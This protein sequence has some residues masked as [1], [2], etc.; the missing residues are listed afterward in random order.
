MGGHEFQFKQF[1]I[2]QDR[3]GMKVGTDSV[4][5][6]AWVEIA[7]AQKILD[8]GTGTG[9]IALM[10]AQRSEAQI[11]AVEIDSEAC[12]QARENVAKS[13]WHSRIQIHCGS[14][15]A[16]AETCQTRYELLVTNPPFFENVFK[17][18]HPARRVA[19]HNDQLQPDELLQVAKKLL[20]AHGRLAVIYP[21]STAQYVQEKSQE[22]GLSCIRKLLM[23][24]LP[25]NPIKRILMEF[26]FLETPPHKNFQ[27]TS[28]TI[29][30]SQ[31]NNP[32]IYT[33]EFIALTQD[34]YLKF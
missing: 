23:K 29:R 24:P 19:R 10:L 11:D 6:G 22:F 15:Q 28:I 26:S 16:Y 17:A 32:P 30:S 25:S 33:D 34:F 1:T 20:T 21:N 14:I 13:Y 2:S 18:N 27:E 3:C 9:L 12:Q 8:I 7:N 31:Q 4:L 5:L